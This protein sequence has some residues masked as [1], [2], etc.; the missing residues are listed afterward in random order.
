MANSKNKDL[1]WRLF[2][3]TRKQL[4]LGIGVFMASFLVVILA[5]IPQINTIGKTNAKLAKEQGELDKVTNKYKELEQV[6]LSPEFAQA[7]KIDAIL[8][9]K[10]PLL[11]LMNGLNTVAGLTQVAVGELTISPGEIATS[12]AQLKVSQTAKAY[13]HIELEITVTGQLAN[14]QQFMVMIEQISPITTITKIALNQTNKGKT[15]ASVVLTTAR[16][17]LS[18]SYFTQQ[19]KTTLTSALPKISEREKEIFETIQSFTIP[20][21]DAQTEV[22]GGGETDPFNIE[23]FDN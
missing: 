8:P 3:Y 17:S 16:L 4:L 23:R 15:D 5:I 19:I 20:E 1:Y 6:K 7:D 18:T 13:D 12:S 9:S 21:A 2:V 10:K 14:I 11:E 22:Q